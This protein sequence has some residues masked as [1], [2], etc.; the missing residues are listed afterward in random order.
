MRLKMFWAVG[1]NLFTERAF[2]VL[3]LDREA[4]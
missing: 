1:E 3:P 2:T 4:E